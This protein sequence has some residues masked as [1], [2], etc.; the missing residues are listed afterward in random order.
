MWISDPSLKSKVRGLLVL[1]T[2]YIPNIRTRQEFVVK[3]N[4]MFISPQTTLHREYISR[5]WDANNETWRSAIWT[6]LDK[7]FR[8]T[9]LE[10]ASTSPA[11]K[12]GWNPRRQEEHDSDDP[13]EGEMR[14]MMSFI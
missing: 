5:G 9:D 4:W 11:W 1:M 2:T 8:N 13:D 6:S 7:D 3:R 12:L 10:M 14:E